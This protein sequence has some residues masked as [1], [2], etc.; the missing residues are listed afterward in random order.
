MSRTVYNQLLPKFEI[1]SP[2][3][4]L[5][6]ENRYHLEADNVEEDDQIDNQQS[7][8]YFKIKH[9]HLR[10][11]RS[12]F[13]S[14]RIT[15]Y[16]CPIEEGNDHT[17]SILRKNKLLSNYNHQSREVTACSRTNDSYVFPTIF[18]NFMDEIS[19]SPSH[20]YTH[21]PFGGWYIL[22]VIFTSENY[23]V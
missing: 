11:V 23:V 8:E 15:L 17:T 5:D 6:A 2:L 19:I 21:I 16:D 7:R 12:G 9:N 10:I 22:T 13:Y 3:D 18:C 14:F 1:V 4:C 20:G